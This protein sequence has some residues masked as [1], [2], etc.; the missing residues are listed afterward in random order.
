MKRNND[1]RLGS[2]SHRKRYEAINVEH[3]QQPVPLVGRRQGKRNTVALQ[4]Q[5]SHANGKCSSKN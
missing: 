3:P 4:E 2:M 5:T 1:L